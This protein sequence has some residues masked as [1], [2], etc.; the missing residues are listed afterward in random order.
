MR[1]VCRAT[2]K[3]HNSPFYAHAGSAGTSFLRAGCFL[4][5]DNSPF[6]IVS[7]FACANGWAY[8]M[9][10]HAPICLGPL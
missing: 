1:A 7:L 10:A 4:A 2:Y 5:D 6:Y 9:S 3:K 8:C